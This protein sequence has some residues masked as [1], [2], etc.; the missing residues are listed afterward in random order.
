ML[1]I[2]KN[3]ASKNSKRLIEGNIFRLSPHK[4]R[5]FT[6]RSHRLRISRFRLYR[7]RPH[8]LRLSGSEAEGGGEGRRSN[9]II[10]SSMSRKKLIIFDLNNFNASSC[11]NFYY[12]DI[13]VIQH[14][15]FK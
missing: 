9:E 7:L 14:C 3:K 13:S 8:K 1:V 10:Y 6:L 4:L 5:L 15:T 2:Y 12:H 11:H